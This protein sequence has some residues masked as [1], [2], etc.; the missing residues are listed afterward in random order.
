MDGLAALR[1]P[2]LPRPKHGD[3]TADR[4]KHVRVSFLDLV[5]NE[6]S[7]TGMIR[8]QGAFYHARK[9]AGGQDGAR[10]GIQIDWFW[11]YGRS[12]ACHAFTRC[13]ICGLAPVPICLRCAATKRQC[14]QARRQSPH[15][16]LQPSA[17]RT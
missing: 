16:H 8:D 17:F 9:I 6:I 5:V 15:R 1:P 13:R 12:F 14:N 2:Y 7:V 3:L 11:G 10:G 4:F